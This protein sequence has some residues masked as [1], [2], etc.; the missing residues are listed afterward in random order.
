M[1]FLPAA[2]KDKVSVDADLGSADTAVSCQ[3]RHKP[4]E[5][6]HKLRTPP[7]QQNMA[8]TAPARTDSVPT[9]SS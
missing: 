5:V 4:R 3:E 2:E 6:T 8:L 7:L 9:S 1:F